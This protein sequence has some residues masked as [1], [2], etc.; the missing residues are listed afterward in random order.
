MR[1][2]L[3]EP[4]RIIFH[5]RT[6]RINMMVGIAHIAW[7]NNSRILRN[8]R[9]FNPI[10]G[11]PPDLISER[12][13]FKDFI[14]ILQKIYLWCVSCKMKAYPEQEWRFKNTVYQH[15]MLRRCSG[16]KSDLVQLLCLIADSPRFHHG[17]AFVSDPFLSTFNSKTKHLEMGN[18]VVFCDN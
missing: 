16:A 12:C 15:S 4:N 17:F 6:H 10:T 14:A 3:I 1:L 13:L 11:N 9:I 18:L 2:L 7:I 8:A 5:G